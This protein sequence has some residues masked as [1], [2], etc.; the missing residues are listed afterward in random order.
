[1]FS[2]NAETRMLH[3]YEAASLTD[4]HLIYFRS[5]VWERKQ[6]SEKSDQE[7]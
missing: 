2:D 1:M 7:H 3:E 6:F 5:P 4:C